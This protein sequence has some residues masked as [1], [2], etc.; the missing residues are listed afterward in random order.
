[1]T[2]TVDET[3]QAS[4]PGQIRISKSKY[5]DYFKVSGIKRLKYFLLFYLPQNIL[6]KLFNS[7]KIVFDF[8]QKT[9][10]FKY[11]CLNPTVVINKDRGIIATFTNLTSYGDDITPVIKISKEPLELI[12][13]LKIKNGQKL[14]TVALYTRNENDELATAWA[15]FDPKI[16]NC[17]TDDIAACNTL[18][19]RISAN[20]WQCL[21]N[22][23]S[24]I[25]N[26]EQI[27]LYYIDLE[28]D[29]VRDAY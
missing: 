6:F 20:G 22:G 8:I 17:F 15:D 13:N 16:A 18:L 12:T 4:T 11:G 28:D 27:G 29:L 24:Q 7:D 10:Q 23:L 25:D 9:E 3:T 14:P 5:L 2:H 1:M 19:G 26:T 21:A